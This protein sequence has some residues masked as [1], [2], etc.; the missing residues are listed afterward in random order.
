MDT[1]AGVGMSL[2]SIADLVA[3]GFVPENEGAGLDAVAAR[4]AITIT[5]EMAAL[6]DPADPNDPIARQFV[7]TLNELHR[8]PDEDA[9]PIGDDV[10]SAVKGLVHRYPD[11]VLLKPLHTCPI[12]CRFCFRREMVG[13]DGA[14]SMTD[15]ELTAA[16]AY[17][18]AHPE[19]FEV[20]VSGGDPLMLSPRRIAA[21][22][23]AASLIP[24]VKVMR[25]HSRVPLVDPTRI[26]ADLI[27]ALKQFSGAVYVA[28]HANHPREF[29]SAGRAAVARLIDN[30]IVLVSQTVLLRGVNDD[31]A[32]LEDLMRTFVA[33]RVNP[34]YLHHGDL[35]PGTSHFR[36]TIAE[37]QA[38]MRGLRGRL[39]GIA[40]PTYV[41]DL[42]GGH[43]KVPVGP[44]YLAEGRIAD[45]GGE[46]HVYPP[47]N[48][49]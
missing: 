46:W 37:G 12:Y 14:G 4:Y 47:D 48:A 17:I 18:A 44:N 27:A 42:P 19:I 43:G 30:G 16:I 6:I 33:N 34:Y 41:V 32:V 36:T 26:D 35:A 31:G 39:S 24:H 15:A 25:W 9:D 3:A 13:P 5:P 11:R 29:A 8:T 45:P 49:G 1:A 23:Q 21:I 7:P 22:A 20:I 28:L 10:H 40:Q 38:L 2:R